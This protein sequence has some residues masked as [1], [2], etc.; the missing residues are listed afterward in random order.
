[1]SIP[2]R[3]VHRATVYD[4]P[5]QPRSRRVA[6]FTSLCGLRSG[7]WLASFQVGSKKHAA[8]S[9]VQICRSDDG[10]VT[11][12]Q[13]DPHFSTVRRGVPGSLAAGE[14]LEV[15]PGRLLLF[16]TWYDR[17]EPDR[18]LFDPITEGILRSRQWVAESVDDGRSWS[19]WREVP[20]DPLTGCATTGPPLS[21]SDGRIAYAFESFKEFDDPRPAPHRAW[22][23]EST[24]GGR[25]FGPPQLVAFDPSERLYYWDQRLCAA[26]RPGEFVGLFWTHQRAA[27]RD[28][29]VHFV[30]GSLT[31]LGDAR[32]TPQE[33]PIR[34]QI[35]A[36]AVLRDGRIAALV[37][38]RAGP[39]TIRLWCSPDGGN[40]WPS[41]E[42]L[43]V[44]EHDERAM[45]HQQGREIDFAQYW[46][47]MGKWSFGHPALRVVDDRRLLAAW[48]AGEPEMMSVHCAIVE[49]D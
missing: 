31:A 25:H 1:M 27:Q 30:R 37:V 15:A 2:F 16:S 48:Y 45:L 5:R 4:A 47:D 28:V 41:D 35:A 43:V 10:G 12:R 3:I 44:Y 17:S 7:A 19:D 46:E 42:S 26:D 21:W 49:T 36:P 39:C 24:D 20:T 40:S 14:L 22:L 29:H 34:G 11:W 8:D 13:L 23:L 6:C 9:T 38:D 32:A 33:T 18:P